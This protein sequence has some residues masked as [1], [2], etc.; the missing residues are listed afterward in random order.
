M[1]RSEPFFV[2]EH[3]LLGLEIPPSAC[4]KHSYISL[5]RYQGIPINDK[6]TSGATGIVDLL[7]ETLTSKN[8]TSGILKPIRSEHL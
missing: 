5:W 7:V 6:T 3:G 1:R 4:T 2:E 8:F